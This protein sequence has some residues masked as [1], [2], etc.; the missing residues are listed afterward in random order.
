MKHITR[1]IPVKAFQ[2]LHH[3]SSKRVDRLIVGINNI[4]DCKLCKHPT[5]DHGW[6][7]GIGVVHP[8]DWITDIA[9]QTLILRNETY[10]A[11]LEKDNG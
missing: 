4:P 2:W 7:E 1:I 5:V 6:M 11:L 8:T 9:G 3:G 10:Q